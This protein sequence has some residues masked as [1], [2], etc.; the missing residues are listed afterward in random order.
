M[1][2]MSMLR[3]TH[4]FTNKFELREQGKFTLFPVATNFLSGLPVLMLQMT[5]SPERVPV[6]ASWFGNTAVHSA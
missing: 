3:H 4:F 5:S 6:T 1:V 2:L